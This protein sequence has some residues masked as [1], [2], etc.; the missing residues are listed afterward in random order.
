GTNILWGAYG[1][2]TVFQLSPP[3]AKGGAWSEVTIYS[4]QG[5]NDGAWPLGGV[6]AVN[7]AFYGTTS[8]G[9]TK[10][11]GTIFM[12]YPGPGGTW[13]EAS[14]YNFQ[15]GVDGA[16][17]AAALTVAPTSASNGQVTLYGTTQFGGTSGNGTV[18]AATLPP[19]PS[20]LPPFSAVCN[21]NCLKNTLRWRLPPILS[22]IGP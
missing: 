22:T 8:A 6:V 9:G 17:P 14:L 2:G 7:G 4:F 12:V 18:F 21:L 10:S 11:S 19:P 3:F 16:G 15:D 1:Q 13:A 20:V 5:G